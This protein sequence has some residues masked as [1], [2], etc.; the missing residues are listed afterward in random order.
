[1]I[2]VL[3]TPLINIGDFY[4]TDNVGIPD[5]K[6]YNSIYQMFY[7]KSF[8]LVHFTPHQQFQIS[9]ETSLVWCAYAQLCV[10]LSIFILK[11]CMLSQRIKDYNCW[12]NKHCQK[13]KIRQSLS[14]LLWKQ[15]CL[16]SGYFELF[17]WKKLRRCAT[18]I[19]YVCTVSK[20]LLKNWRSYIHK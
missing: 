17:G 19:S 10:H 20:H 1:M 4:W 6:V 7:R 9:I 2:Q 3:G 18:V 13:G 5:Y 16:Q 14:C 8:V 15:K 12:G 11:S